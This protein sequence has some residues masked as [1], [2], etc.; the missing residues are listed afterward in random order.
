VTSPTATNSFPRIKDVTPE[1]VTELQRLLRRAGES[2]VAEQVAHL[3]M[4]DRCRCGD[5]FCASFYT[6]PRPVGRFGPGHRTI[7][8]L[9]ENGILNVDVIGSTI[10]HVEVLRR[11]ELRCKI[12]A[13]V[14]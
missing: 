10:V 11:D 14:P 5:S 2:A 8:L 6:A 4:V 7:P 12:C 13:A 9:S 3:V 1:L